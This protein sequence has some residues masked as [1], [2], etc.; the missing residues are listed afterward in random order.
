MFLGQIFAENAKNEPK[1]LFEASE[2]VKKKIRKM[3]VKSRN[4]VKSACFRHVLCHISAIFED[5]DLEFCTYIHETLLS[6]ICYCF[7]KILIWWETVSKSKKMGIF[8]GFFSLE[9]FKILKI[10]DGSFVALL[11]LRHFI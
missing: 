8:W 6:N 7:L 4:D 3:T 2:S 1:T 5:I 9:I 11:I 10:R